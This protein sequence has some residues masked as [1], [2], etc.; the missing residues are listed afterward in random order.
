MLQALRLLLSSLLALQRLELAL[1]LI[2]IC[3]L[4]L[5]LLPSS[6]LA[7]QQLES[8]VL[9]LMCGLE[10]ETSP[11]GECAVPANYLRY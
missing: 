8:F 4:E 9:I 7:L 1:F 6:L 11:E 3:G 5:R 10:P 2:L